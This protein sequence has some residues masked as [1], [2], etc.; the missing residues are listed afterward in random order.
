MRVFVVGLDGLE[1]TLVEKL[2]LRH[3]K[4]VE[5]GKVQLSDAP[6]V[7]TPILWASFISGGFEHGVAGFTVKN[8]FLQTSDRL[9]KKL[10]INPHSIKAVWET[11]RFLARLGVA[12]SRPVTKADWRTKTLFDEVPNSVAVS[13]PAYNEWKSIHQMRL[14][15]PFIGL[16]EMGRLK[17]ADECVKT[18][19]R[20]FHQKI[21]YTQVLLEKNYDLLMVHFLILDTIGHL[22]WH[23]PAKIKDAYRFVN[24][25]VATLASKA[26]DWFILIVSDHGMKRGLHTDYAFYSSNIPLGLKDPK[27]TDFHDIILEKM[28]S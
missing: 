8:R 11:Y 15:Y 7:L 2:N 10:R 28:K 6:K 20:I 13:I 14:D 24:S 1:Y 25:A 17:E 18:N 12:R 26:K 21:R 22:Y 5:Y 4:Q 19:W 16:V 23:K 9:L 27:L 3:I